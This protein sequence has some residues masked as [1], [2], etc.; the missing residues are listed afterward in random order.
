MKLWHSVRRYFGTPQRKS[1]WPFRTPW[2]K[3]LHLKCLKS[4][5]T[6]FLDRMIFFKRD[7]ILKKEE[8]KRANFAQDM[9][10]IELKIHNFWKIKVFLLWRI[11]SFFK[12][13]L[14][15]LRRGPSSANFWIILLIV[16]F[17]K[18]KKEKKRKLSLIKKWIYM[19]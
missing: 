5:G 15:D 12:K 1:L 16:F 3:P 10:K 17:L 19:T 6:K 2:R 8:I 4:N 18:K 7:V 9:S 14:Y 11:V 13:I